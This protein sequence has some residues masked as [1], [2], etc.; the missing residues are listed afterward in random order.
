MTSSSSGSSAPDSDLVESLGA[1]V[2]EADPATFQF[3][4][5]NRAAERLLGYPAH[6][7]LSRP[8]FWSEILHPDDRDG[9]VAARRSAVAERRNH[10][11][12]Y[13]VMAADG[14]VRCMREIVSV[15][16]GEGGSAMRLRGL[17]VDVTEARMRL[18]HTFHRGGRMEAFARITT[19]VA[20]DLRNVFTVVIANV[21]LAL[22]GNAGA[23]VRLELTEI[24][25]AAYLG[26]AVIEQLASFGGRHRRVTLV[27]VNVAVQDVRTFLERLLR[28]SAEL[29][30]ETTAAQ[31][32]VLTE[33]GAVQQILLNLIVNAKEAMSAT[34]GRVAI[35]TRNVRAALP[36]GERELRDLVEIEVSDTG[37]GMAPHVCARIF[38]LHFTTKEERRG[39]G[40]GLATVAAIVRD[41]GGT[42]SVESQPERGTTFRVRLP[43]VPC[44]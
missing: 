15:I 43:V 32:C 29:A 31:S 5:V 16:R 37:V 18:E 13:R 24:R 27:D 30:V 44:S 19:A 7:W 25:E 17:M 11:F 38:E 4:Y 8:A 2:W 34:R 40:I 9:A 41:A 20:H 14:S 21:D 23:G 6:A 42:I 26:K 22:D 10:D 39:S 36:G 28:P 1:I 35:A 3:L 33:A 12:E